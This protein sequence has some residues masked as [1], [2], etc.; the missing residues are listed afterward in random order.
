MSRDFA[1]ENFT[2]ILSGKKI[3]PLVINYDGKGTQLEDEKMTFDLDFDGKTE[4]ISK[5]REGSGFLALDKN[6]DGT[7]NDGSELFGTRTGDGF[8]ELEK[9][10]TDKNG[11]IDEAD[12]IFEKL[13]IWETTPTGETRLFTLSEKGIGA[14]F[15]GK[16]DTLFNFKSEETNQNNGTMKSSSIYLRETGEAGYIHQI[17]LTV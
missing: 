6:S 8:G 17:D 11:W 4:K 10:D 13:T 2:H 12:E 1:Q 9:Y 15:L 3:D 5:I 16:T 7:I 14:I